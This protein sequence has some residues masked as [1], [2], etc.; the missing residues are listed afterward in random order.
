M[1]LKILGFFKKICKFHSVGVLIKNHRLLKNSNSLVLLNLR[2]RVEPCM[3][4]LI[5]KRFLE[6]IFHEFW[7]EDLHC[8][9]QPEQKKK[10]KKKKKKKILMFEGYDLIDPMK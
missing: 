10:K 8:E 9:K 7:S 4:N 3:V 2:V 1:T 5:Q 6:Y